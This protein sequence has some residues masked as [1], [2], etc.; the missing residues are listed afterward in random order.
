MNNIEKIFRIYP[1]LVRTSIGI[2]FH[3]I[4]L[5]RRTFHRSFPCPSVHLNFFPSKTVNIFFVLGF[6]GQISTS[7]GNRTL[8]IGSEHFF[9]RRI[10]RRRYWF[11]NNSNTTH[12]SYDLSIFNFL[13]LNERKMSILVYLPISRI[14]KLKPIFFTT[15]HLPVIGRW[16]GARRFIGRLRSSLSGC[17]SFYFIGYRRWLLSLNFRRSHGFLGKNE[18]PTD[19]N[20]SNDNEN[21]NNIYK[22]LLT[23]MIKNFSSPKMRNR[24]FVFTPKIEYQLVAERSEANLLNLQIPFWCRG[25][26]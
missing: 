11:L 19:C 17:R 8:R 24:Q 16:R 14:L 7:C 23:H 3:S 26:E 18:I 22:S 6:T 21:Q 4:P 12:D 1:K 25:R 15:I 20:N 9:I 13:Q 2:N 5:G 10:Y